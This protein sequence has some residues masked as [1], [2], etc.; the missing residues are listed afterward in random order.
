M[1]YEFRTR[2]VLTETSVVVVNA[3][4]LYEALATLFH[5]ATAIQ[6]QKDEYRIEYVRVKCV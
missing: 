5:K 6:K 2:I 3:V 4:V 1:R